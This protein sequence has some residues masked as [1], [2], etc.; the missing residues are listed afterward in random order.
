[1]IRLSFE[2]TYDIFSFKVTVSL[3]KEIFPEN[4][5]YRN[6]VTMK[7]SLKLTY[8]TLGRGGGN[9]YRIWYFLHGSENTPFV[10]TFCILNILIF[11]RAHK[12]R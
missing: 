2:D 6:V 7:S 8:K 10:Y 4:E 9:Q 1:M 5:M 11:E 12:Y 3:I